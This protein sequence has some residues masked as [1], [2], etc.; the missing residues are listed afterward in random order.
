MSQSR[1][2]NESVKIEVREPHTNADSEPC[3]R[4][5]VGFVM[6]NYLIQDLSGC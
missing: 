2:H 3:A 6:L 1:Q 4:V 5:N